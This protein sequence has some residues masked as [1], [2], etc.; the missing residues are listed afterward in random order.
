MPKSGH[1]HRKD[2]AVFVKFETVDADYAV[3]SVGGTERMYGVSDFLNLIH[4]VFTKKPKWLTA[5]G[6]SHFQLPMLII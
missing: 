5:V 1:L 6:I 3:V 4:F 2:E